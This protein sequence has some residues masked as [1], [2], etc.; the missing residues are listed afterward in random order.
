MVDA[1]QVE[2]TIP[3]CKRCGGPR[4]PED[5]D[6]C[7]G[8]CKKCRF[9]GETFGALWVAHNRVKNGDAE[10]ESLARFRD[11]P[12]IERYACELFKHPAF[13][14]DTWDRLESWFLPEGVTGRNCLLETPLPVIH[15]NF[16]N[17]RTPLNAVPVILP[18]SR[19]GGV[20]EEV[21]ETAESKRARASV[22]RR[23]A[24]DI[25]A[26]AQDKV[27]V[28]IKDMVNL[29][30][31]AAKQDA[32]DSPDCANL[33][34]LLRNPD[35]LPDTEKFRSLRNNWFHGD[36]RLAVWHAIA[37]CF[38]FQDK[39]EYGNEE[40]G[41]E[42]FWSDARQAIADWLDEKAAII[43]SPPPAAKTGAGEGNGGKGIASRTTR[44]D[45]LKERAWNN[46]VVV[47]F[48]AI[49]AVVVSLAALATGLENLFNC[50][51]HFIGWPR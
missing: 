31:E 23:I 30:I 28:A 37:C 9:T 50:L 29:L 44:W 12:E 41:R 20:R 16:R 40:F 5:G 21:D 47:A 38:F 45:R 7:Y 51:R 49:A 17:A 25:R 27:E 39:D 15:L 33:R 48:L 46:R 35:E 43:E 19:T 32:F 3:P 14:N 8:L 11:W 24:A 22:L 13:T 34:A 42:R 10:L 18:P 36:N 2:V 1:D 4:S 6:S 26:V